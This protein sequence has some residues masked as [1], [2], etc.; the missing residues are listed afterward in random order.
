M[1][2]EDN[3]QIKL[4]AKF[5]L[6]R[7]DSMNKWGGAHSELKR[8]LK[9]LP[10]HIRDSNQGKKQINKAAKLLTNLDFIFIKPSTGELHASLNP[11]MK[12]EIYEFIDENEREEYN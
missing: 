3:K 11:R 10:S 4:I 2:E 1:E 12:R 8:V 5:I 7:L 6:E 9:S